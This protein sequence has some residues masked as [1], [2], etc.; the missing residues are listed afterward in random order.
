[1]PDEQQK[2]QRKKWKDLTPG[3]RILTVVGAL[4]Q[5]T[6]LVL[7]QRD[8]AKRPV[9]QVKGP[10]WVWR[11]VTMINFLGPISYFAFG[12]RKPQSA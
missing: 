11:I 8:L 9:E 10:K 12:T 2:K 3:Q 5:F 6:L 1:M 4:I 7:A